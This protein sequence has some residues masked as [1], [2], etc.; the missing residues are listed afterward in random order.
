MTWD[1]H[2][3]EHRS[4]SGLITKCA[5]L[6]LEPAFQLTINAMRASITVFG[7]MMSR[8]EWL[9]Q[10]ELDPTVLPNSLMLSYVHYTPYRRLQLLIGKL[11]FSA[12]DCSKSNMLAKRHMNCGRG[13]HV[14]DQLSCQSDSGRLLHHYL[15]PLTLL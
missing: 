15:Y 2:T 14:Y 7:D 1:L 12:S 5:S 10:F 13:S 11:L 9:I 6:I 3:Q 4:Y 8:S